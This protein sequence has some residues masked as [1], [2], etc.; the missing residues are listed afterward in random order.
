[1]GTGNSCTCLAL[2]ICD[3]RSMPPV[4]ICDHFPLLFLCHLYSC[5]QSSDIDGMLFGE[6]VGQRKASGGCLGASR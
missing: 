2:C 4:L 6:F 1:M 3:I 5:L